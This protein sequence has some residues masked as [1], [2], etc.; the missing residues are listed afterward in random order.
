VETGP[1]TGRAIG[2]AIA[3][4]RIL[5]PGLLESTHQQCLAHELRLN[6]IER[7]KL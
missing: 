3:V 2:C 6:G 7:F 5:G 4:H 1:F